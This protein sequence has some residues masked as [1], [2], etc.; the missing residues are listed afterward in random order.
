MV[1]IRAELE[2]KILE[3]NQRASS[4]SERLGQIDQFNQN[5]AVPQIS[6]QGPKGYNPMNSLQALFQMI[7]G[8][9]TV[10]QD[11]ESERTSGLNALTQLSD[12]EQAN[13]PKEVDSL[14]KITKTLQAKKLAKEL[15]LDIDFET[16]EVKSTESTISPEKQRIISDIDEVLGRDTKSITGL[17]RLG[18]VIPGSE[19]MTT[20]AK[21]EQIKNK[22]SL[23]EREKLKGTGTISDYEAQM[24]DKSV[25]ALNYKMSDEDFKAE[26][27]KI[28]GILSGEYK[29][30]SE[31]KQD[32]PLGIL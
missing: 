18:G 1:D 17:L 27:E 25:A 5:T 32:D 28:R 16:G 31:S 30:G 15:G 13:K 6:S 19:G 9:K 8:R 23:T 10:Q 12:Y 14:D 21:V 22:L 4:L 24:L 26:L 2:K 11:V 29:D 20:K 7:S 3:S